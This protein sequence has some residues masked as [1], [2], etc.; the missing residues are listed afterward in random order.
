ML[1]IENTQGRIKSIV[2][3]YKAGFPNEYKAVCEQIAKKRR[4]NEDEYASTIGDHSLKR[5]IHEIPE[6]LSISLYKGLDEEENQWFISKK[7]AI[8]FAKT[9]PEFKS[10]HKI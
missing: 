4:L 7:G 10:S 9:F 5:R 8:W 1:S 3:I 2:K 6:K